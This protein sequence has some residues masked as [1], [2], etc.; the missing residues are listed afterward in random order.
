MLTA[1]LLPTVILPGTCMRPREKCCAL[2][3]PLRLCCA[4]F[5]H[6]VKFSERMLCFFKA[7]G[8]SS[9][10]R[11]SPQCLCVIPSR[12]LWVLKCTQCCGLK[13]L[14]KYRHSP[15][16]GPVVWCQCDLC[17]HREET[18][19]DTF[20][21]QQG[22]QTV[23]QSTQTRYK[24]LPSLASASPCVILPRFLEKMSQAAAGN[25]NGREECPRAWFPVVY[26]NPGPHPQL[27]AAASAWEAMES[28]SPQPVLNGPFCTP[29]HSY[30]QS[31]CA[32]IGGFLVL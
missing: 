16:L 7:Q 2:P 24:N 27:T 6:Y 3:H 8:V 20:S 31:L 11:P 21:P 9:L 28:C 17:G 29:P 15:Q 14:S 25:G 26:W 5:R 18:L 22:A 1:Q 10:C 19:D 30:V 13:M 4:C 12:H 23:N 32:G